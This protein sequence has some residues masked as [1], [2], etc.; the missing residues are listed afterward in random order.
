MRALVAAP[1]KEQIHLW[2]TSCA[3]S[4]ASGKTVQPWTGAEPAPRHCDLSFVNHKGKA[5]RQATDGVFKVLANQ[6]HVWRAKAIILIAAQGLVAV[7]IGTAECRLKIE[8]HDVA[9]RRHRERRKN[10]HA[11]T[12][13]KIP[14][15]L[16]A[17]GT[18]CTLCGKTFVVLR[19]FI[20]ETFRIFRVSIDRALI[21]PVRISWHNEASGLP[22]DGELVRQIRRQPLKRKRRASRRDVLLVVQVVIQVKPIV[23]Q[24]RAHTDTL[25]ELHR[26]GLIRESRR[27]GFRVERAD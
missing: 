12:A 18:L 10:A 20:H 22:V 15:K 3:K 6:Q 11:K 4:E 26:A 13:L 16:L 14:A 9:A 17:V 5:Q 23:E 25:A 8:R 1:R 7:D 21:R 19:E 2:E 24:H 27:S